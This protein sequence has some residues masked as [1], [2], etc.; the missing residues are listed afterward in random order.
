M[1]IKRPASSNREPTVSVW[2]QEKLRQL[3]S[4]EVRA[5]HG[6]TSYDPV[7]AMALIGCDPANSSDPSLV[8]SAHKEVAKY[9][10]PTLKQVE[11][12]GPGGGPVSVESSEAKEL[13]D[14][15]RQVISKQSQGET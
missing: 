7:V 2:Q 9:L 14:L 10:H 15:V 8:L 4:D 3:I 13:V 5:R 6:L 11:V 12:A 1:S